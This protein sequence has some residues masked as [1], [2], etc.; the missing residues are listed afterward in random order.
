M[1]TGCKASKR[2]YL[3]R[4]FGH[5]I[6]NIKYKFL[7]CPVSPPKEPEEFSLASIQGFHCARGDSLGLSL[8]FV[9]KLVDLHLQGTCP[10]FK[11]FNAWDGM[12]VLHSGDIAAEKSGAPFNVALGEFLPF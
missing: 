5:P 3:H 4:F 12:P 8:P 2:F 6:S 11:S 1:L 7:I 10:S 9:E